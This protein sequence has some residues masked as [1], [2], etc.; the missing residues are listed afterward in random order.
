MLIK[1]NTFKL[2]AHTNGMKLN[3]SN[4]RT[5]YLNSSK[6]AKIIRLIDGEQKV[7]WSIMFDDYQHIIYLKDLPDNLLLG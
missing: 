7:F 5:E 6:I 3:E 2:E 1:V 4:S